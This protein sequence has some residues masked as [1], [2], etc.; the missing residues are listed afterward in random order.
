MSQDYINDT[1]GEHVSTLPK[2]QKVENKAIKLLVGISEKTI[3]YDEIYNEFESVRRAMVELDDNTIGP[4]Y[5]L[6]LSKFLAF[7]FMKWRDW[8]MLQKI[9]KEQPEQFDTDEAQERYNEIKQMELDEV[10]FK[11][12][13]YCLG[14]LGHKIKE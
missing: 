5:P 12:C 6:W 3:A 1:F 7:H 11:T 9:Y 2:Y 4:G 14:E 8:Y 10:F 13:R